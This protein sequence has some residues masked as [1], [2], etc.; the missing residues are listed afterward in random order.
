MNMTDSQR[1]GSKSG[2]LVGLNTLLSFKFS[3]GLHLGDINSIGYVCL[4]HILVM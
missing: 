2:L 3:I 1:I 4:Q